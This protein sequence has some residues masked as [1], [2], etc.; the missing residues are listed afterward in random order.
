MPSLF[1]P[2]PP[3]FHP[4]P[5][6]S[7]KPLVYVDESKEGSD[8]DESQG[9]AEEFGG[10]VGGCDGGGAAGT[11]GG[12]DNDAEDVYPYAYWD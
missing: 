3:P 8:E 11:D 12:V 10:R 4:M 1:L 7:L 5:F 9:K 6:S 2:S